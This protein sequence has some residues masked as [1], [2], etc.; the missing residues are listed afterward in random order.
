MDTEESNSAPP[1]IKIEIKH[2]LS[3]LNS[4]AKGNV[5]AE[6]KSE[7]IAAGTATISVGAAYTVAIMQMSAATENI[8]IIIDVT[9]MYTGNSFFMSILYHNLRL[10]RR[11]LRN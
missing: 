2:S 8:K 7:T 10:L 4:T 6:R 3:R 11:L 9:S 1:P 5:I